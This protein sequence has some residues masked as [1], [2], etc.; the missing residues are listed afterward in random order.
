MKD[1][2]VHGT[3]TYP[4]ASILVMAIEAVKQF[5]MLFERQA[6]GFHFRDVE[7]RK[8]LMIPSNEIEVQFHMR[9]PKDKCHGFLQWNEFKLYV[10]ESNAWNF[11]SSGF[12]AVEYL[13]HSI[14]EAVMTDLT[15]RDCSY[16]I[17]KQEF[18]QRFKDIGLA[19]GP[20]FQGLRDIRCSTSNKAAANV[21]LYAWKDALPESQYQEVQPYTI[22]PAALDAIFQSVFAAL[23]GTQAKPLPTLVPT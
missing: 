17:D 7:I 20:S 1:H 5:Q 6:R 4:A 18:Y 3:A 19:F 16:T 2:R 21:N 22:H 23:S 8:A 9:P 11:V 10:N 14:R 12:I 15:V 13:D